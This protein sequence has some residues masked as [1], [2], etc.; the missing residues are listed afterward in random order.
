MDTVITKTCG[1]TQ[2][3]CYLIANTAPLKNADQFYLLY[4]N[5]QTSK[6]ASYS[7]PKSSLWMICWEQNTISS[8]SDSSEKKFIGYCSMWSVSIMKKHWFILVDKLSFYSI[9]IGCSSYIISVSEVSLLSGV[10]PM[11]NSYMPSCF[12]AAFCIACSCL[13]MAEDRRAPITVLKVMPWIRFGDRQS[14]L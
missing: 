9:V 6:Y 8:C 5:I 7:S 14:M 11:K 10:Q 3:S 13:A 12:L 1:K 4:S 2:D